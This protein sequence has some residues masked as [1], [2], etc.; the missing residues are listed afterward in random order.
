MHYR[1][2]VAKW[3]N[4]IRLLFRLSLL[5]SILADLFLELHPEW[6]QLVVYG[7]DKTE[8]VAFVIPIL[9]LRKHLTTLFEEVFHIS[10]VQYSDRHHLLKYV[11]CISDICIICTR[12]SRPFGPS[13]ACSGELPIRTGPNY[14]QRQLQSLIVKASN[15]STTEAN[16]LH[17]CKV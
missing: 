13:A 4:K 16:K 9:A 7:L 15:I 8:K 14:L 11:H 3:K 12:T 17:A 10:R 6:L 1:Q 2:F 5:M